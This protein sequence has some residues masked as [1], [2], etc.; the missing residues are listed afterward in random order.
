[1]KY[2]PFPT[3]KY[4]KSYLRLKQSGLLKQNIRHR[5]DEVVD[6]L[7]RGDMLPSSYRDHQLSGDMKMYRECHIKGDLLLVYQIQKDKLVLVLIDIGSHSYLDI[8]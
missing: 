7:S 3:K 6:M 5:L 2:V 8:E 4:E 1:M